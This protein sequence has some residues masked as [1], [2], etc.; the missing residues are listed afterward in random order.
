M[1][2]NQ[3]L[4]IVVLLGLLISLAGCDDCSCGEYCHVEYSYENGRQVE[5]AVCECITNC[6]PT[7]AP[8]LQGG[9]LID[10]LNSRP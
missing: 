8:K 1:K 7:P 3:I 2:R 9:K 6:A 4:I 5:K 10:A